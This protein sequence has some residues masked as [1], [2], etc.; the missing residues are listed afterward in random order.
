MFSTYLNKNSS[1]HTKRTLTRAFEK[2]YAG[3]VV[4]LPRWIRERISTVSIIRTIGTFFY[5]IQIVETH[6]TILIQLLCVEI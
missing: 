6:R 4:C 1:C 2:D 3:F 5:A